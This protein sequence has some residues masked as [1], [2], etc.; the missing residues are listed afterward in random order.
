MALV[1]FTDTEW[2]VHHEAL[3]Y[4]ARALRDGPKGTT[5]VD[6]FASFQFGFPTA[7]ALKDGTVLATHWCVEQN[8]CGIRWTKLRVD[9]K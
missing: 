7:I 2:T 9:W 4:D 8:V 5:G 6:E 1:T 3:L